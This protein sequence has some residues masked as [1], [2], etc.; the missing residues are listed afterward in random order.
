MEGGGHVLGLVDGLPVHVRQH[1]TDLDPDVLRRQSALDAA[2]GGGVI[3]VGRQADAEEARKPSVMV[4]VSLPAS[5]CLTI[6]MASLIGM[7]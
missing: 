3:V 4:S 7:A 5:I 1:I 6:A 2:D